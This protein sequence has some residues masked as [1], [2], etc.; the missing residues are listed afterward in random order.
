MN[1]SEFSVEQIKK[2]TQ[3]IIWDSHQSVFDFYSKYRSFFEEIS[4]AQDDESKL[5]FIDIKLHFV[6]VLISTYFYLCPDEIYY[7]QIIP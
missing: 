4:N 1:N 7:H 5:F 2:E 6:D 3:D